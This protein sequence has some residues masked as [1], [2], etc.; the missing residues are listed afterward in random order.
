MGPLVVVLDTDLFFRVK[1]TDALRHAGYTVQNVR[2]AETFSQ[3]LAEHPA[4]ALLNLAARGLA[5]EP[6]IASARAANVPVI[7]FGPHVE[8]ELQAAAR[9]AGATRVIS[10]SKLATD[11]LGVVSR[12]LQPPTAATADTSIDDA[13]TDR[14]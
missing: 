6:A 8:L 7:A 4:L 14:S 13:D 5:W 2:T 3:A 11:L 9:Q 10:N 12:V 1:V